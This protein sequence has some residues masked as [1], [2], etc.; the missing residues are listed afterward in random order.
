SVITFPISLWMCTDILKEYVR[1]IIFTLGP[2]LYGRP[3]EPGLP[4]IL[5]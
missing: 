5:P 3:K 4:F 2:I 1:T